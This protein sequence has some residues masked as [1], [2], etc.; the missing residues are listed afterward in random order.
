MSYNILLQTEALSEIQEAFDWY[1]EQK[2]GLGY[3][4]LEEIELC[5]QKLSE[6]PA[7]YSY[8]NPLYRRI[9]TDRFPYLLVF[10]IE[11]DSII[12]NSVRHIKRKPL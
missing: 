2:D 3:E 7:R 9:K 4:L 10:E 1:E 8:I 5:F 12:I 6:H 11:D